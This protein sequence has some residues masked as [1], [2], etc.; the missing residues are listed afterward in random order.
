MNAHPNLFD[1]TPPLL[2]GPPKATAFDG[3]TYQPEE[4][5][6]RLKTQLWRV[7]QLMSDGNFRTLEEIA[8]VT[9]GSEA[10]VS[11]RLRDLRKDKYGAR[12]IER[13]RVNGG[14]FRY[15]MKPEGD[16][17]LIGGAS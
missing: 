2:P 12:E 16:T 14:L 8:F 5:H 1:W 9:G 3:K 11:A 13:Q 15:R 6:A 4:D 7:F 17:S 10:S